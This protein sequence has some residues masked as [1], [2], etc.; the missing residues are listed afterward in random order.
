M[1]GEGI[2][3]REQLG[4]P[5]RK[6]EGRRRTRRAGVQAGGSRWPAPERCRRVH[7]GRCRNRAADDDGAR[8]RRRR[9]SSLLRRSSSSSFFLLPSP[10]SQLSSLQFLIICVND[11][12]FL[13][14][15]YPHSQVPPILFI[16]SRLWIYITCPFVY[17][18]FYFISSIY[19][20]WLLFFFF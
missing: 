11:P 12:T 1:E 18:H 4:S 10:F 7:L 8:R 19:A 17:L 9:P 6:K 20:R 14:P 3:D 5:G 16:R 2:A 15:F 13:F